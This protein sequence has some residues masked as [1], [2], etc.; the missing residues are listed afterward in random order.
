M[1]ELSDVTTNYS[2]V[3]LN[4]NSSLRDDRVNDPDSRPSEVFRLIRLVLLMTFLTFGTI[5]NIMVFFIMR[6]G[7]LKDV[8]TCFYM[9]ILALAD[10][11]K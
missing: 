5:V 7:S 3:D 6:R 11:G 4:S 9:S 10:T 8:S 1:E 2:Y